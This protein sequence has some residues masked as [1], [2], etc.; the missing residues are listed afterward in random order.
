M[1]FHASLFKYVAVEVPGHKS[2]FSDLQSNLMNVLWK[3]NRTFKWLGIWT[4]FLK[5]L[6]MLS[7]IQALTIDYLVYILFFTDLS[8]G[9]N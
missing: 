1:T 5:G 3:E 6:E 9:Q 4:S 7:Y 8:S 2:Q